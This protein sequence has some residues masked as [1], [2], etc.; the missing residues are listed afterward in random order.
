L[1]VLV[2]PQEAFTGRFSRANKG[3]DSRMR[4]D[5]HPLPKIPPHFCQ[6]EL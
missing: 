3:I 6:D 1:R 5:D 2:R 4:P